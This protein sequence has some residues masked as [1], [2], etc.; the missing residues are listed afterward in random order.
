MLHKGYNILPMIKNHND[1]LGYPI[2]F[3]KDMTHGDISSRKNN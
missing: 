3:Y 1:G 2:T